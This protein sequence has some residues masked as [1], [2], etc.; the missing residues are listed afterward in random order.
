MTRTIWLAAALVTT[1]AT[2]LLL[3]EPRP[4]RPAA[5]ADESIAFTHSPSRDV[6]VEHRFVSVAAPE[7][8]TASVLPTPVRTADS[9]PL[10]RPSPARKADDALLAKARRVVLGDGKY[11]PEPFPRVK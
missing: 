1:A 2:V 6:R 4:D 3:R 7:A 8:R 9:A 10:R 5:P 11:R